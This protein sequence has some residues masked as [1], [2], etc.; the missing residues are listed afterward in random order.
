MPPPDRSALEKAWRWGVANSPA[1]TSRWGR[2]LPLD[3]QGNLRRQAILDLRSVAK[4]TPITPSTVTP[5]TPAAPA[6]PVLPPA[7]MP[8]PVDWAQRG[9]D[10]ARMFG[11]DIEKLFGMVSDDEPAWAQPP[12]APGR[13]KLWS[14]YVE[15]LTTGLGAVEDITAPARGMAFG[16]WVPGLT[17]PGVKRRATE[18]R[19][20]GVGPWAAAGAAYQQAEEAGEIPWWQ[21][22]PVSMLTSPEEAIPGIG[23][24]PALLKGGV[25]LGRAGIRAAAK[26][27]LQDLPREVVSEAPGLAAKDREIL[28]FPFGREAMQR[29]KG[30]A[31]VAISA[32]ELGSQ[33]RWA[34]ALPGSPQVEGVAELGRR[35]GVG[36]SIQVQLRSHPFERSIRAAGNRAGE[37]SG[38]H[39]RALLDRLFDYKQRGVDLDNPLNAEQKR[40]HKMWLDDATRLISREAVAPVPIAAPVRTGVFMRARS[41]IEEAKKIVT[42]GLGEPALVP[43]PAVPEELTAEQILRNMGDPE[44][45]ARE[46]ATQRGMRRVQRERAVLTP[47]EFAELTRLRDGLRAQR[48]LAESVGL[49]EAT[50]MFRGQRTYEADAA[51]RKRIAELESKAA[52][53]TPEEFAELDRGRAAYLEGIAKPPSASKLVKNLEGWSKQ[54]DRPESIKNFENLQPLINAFKGI[55]QAGMK[56]ADYI[57]ARKEAFG[58]IRQFLDELVPVGVVGETVTPTPLGPLSGQALREGRKQIMDYVEHFDE[59]RQK[60]VNTLSSLLDDLPARGSAEEAAANNWYFV[61]DPSDPSRLSIR[62]NRPIRVTKEGYEGLQAES[63]TS[64]FMNS[65]FPHSGTPSRPGTVISP[66]LKELKPYLVRNRN[67]D[68]LRESIVEMQ[69]VGRKK[70]KPIF[71]AAIQ[72]FFGITR[73]HHLFFREVREQGSKEMESLGAVRPDRG[74]T[75]DGSFMIN[76][77]AVGSFE[78][79]GPMRL[80]FRALHAKNG[81]RWL[82]LLK[83]QHGPDW[84]RQYDNLRELAGWEEEL[85]QIANTDMALLQTEDYFYRGWKASDSARA[86]LE[87]ALQGRGIGNKQPY[88]M[89]RV[90]L[91]FEEMEQLGFEP[92]YWNPYDQIITRANQG[93]EGRLQTQLLAILKNPKY[94]L[95]KSFITG[96]QRDELIAEGYRPVE[97]LGSALKPFKIGATPKKFEAREAAAGIPVGGYQVWAN[98]YAFPVKVASAIE[99]LFG[100]QQ[101]SA[102]RKDIIKKIGM[103]VEVSFKLD[104]IVYLPKRVKLFATLF[105]QADF[106]QRG[107]FGAAGAFLGHVIKGMEMLGKEGMRKQGIETILKSHMHLRHM[108]R[109]WGSMLKANVSPEYRATLRAKLRSGESLYAERGKSTLPQGADPSLKEYTWINFIENGLSITDSAILGAEDTIAG[110]REAVSEE[111]WY[112]GGAKNAMRALKELEFMMR[113]G[114]FDGVYVASIMHDV[115]YNIL[116]MVRL[117][118][119]DLTPHEVMAIA[120]RMANKAWSTIPKEQSLIRGS[121][122]EIAKRL[123]FSINENEGLVRSISGMFKGPDKLYWQTRYVGGFLFLGVVA[124]L[125]H[126]ATTSAAGRPELLPLDRYN[127]L[128]LR[129]WDWWKFGYNQALLAPDLPMTT[130]GGERAILDLVMQQDAF[131][132]MAD[133]KDAPI[134]LA[135][136]VSNR[137]SV[138]VR[139]G[140]NQFTGKDFY[141]RDIG[142][143]GWLQ[144]RLQNAYDMFAPIGAG[145]FAVAGLQKAFENK[146]LGL[147]VP[148]ELP[149]GGD[150]IVPGST[151]KD[152]TPMMESKLGSGLGPLFLQGLGFN[153]RAKSNADLREVMVKNTFGSVPQEERDIQ[154]EIWRR[155]GGPKKWPTKWTDISKHPDLT[156]RA[157]RDPVN[158]EHVGEIQRRQDTG[159]RNETYDQF[160][161]MMHAEGE[162]A[163]ERL[164]KE[165][166]LYAD[167]VNGAGMLISQDPKRVAWSPTKWKQAH[168]KINVQFAANREMIEQIYTRD[169]RTAAKLA[170]LKGTEPDPSD[171]LIWALWHW[172]R[173][174]EESSDTLGNVDYDKFE[175]LWDEETRG[176]DE[177]QGLRDRL[178]SYISGGEHHPFV[179]SY[180]NGLKAIEGSGYWQGSF[181]DQERALAA[182]HGISAEQVKERW[183]EYLKA[184]P[185]HRRAM[186]DKGR[187]VD[188]QILKVMT[189]ARNNHR[190]NIRI[191]NPH[192]D[193]LLVFWFGNRPKRYENRTYYRKLYQRTD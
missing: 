31:D 155:E 156:R 189:S 33:V 86:N 39:I 71:D 64:E 48:E 55:K 18:L 2:Q 114:L 15:P 166:T 101:W 116:P 180:Y 153:V 12:R 60:V 93:L 104:D 115:Q 100:G 72:R 158:R 183:N 191:Q 152:I 91:S 58:H 1:L 49:E 69:A 99:D 89:K 124:N 157:K 186:M 6:A 132:R 22:I 5:A 94:G 74:V 142:R 140:L 138:P 66:W 109:H 141:G 62:R 51:A 82:G 177:E 182:I 162:A 117:M 23:I 88:Q 83:A 123:F 28:A 38:L 53:S 37:E 25:R 10:I 29:L 173:V 129:D 45:A 42:P 9:K 7:Q 20:A 131:F 175:R 21:D 181:P 151:V 133:W 44:A 118:H 145:Q 164:V 59:A 34:R 137:L 35:I 3:D 163:K 192:V 111:A 105:Q 96:G 171:G 135:D 178:D 144:A 159:V 185:E 43:T 13:G 184:S 106:A 17:K 107:G 30:P 61:P 187:A 57:A 190:L 136:F 154:L 56:K 32:E 63:A 147:S 77:P 50:P 97:G 127:P 85:T 73:A 26:P 179:Q 8:K 119:P 139:A 172:N 41:A 121:T 98:G 128:N 70:G 174:R 102:F 165:A 87:H 193:R 176:W 46:A 161:Q 110:I 24:G 47:E 130:S 122:R 14:K 143:S 168:R 170:R 188:R 4:G 120:A 19:E 103:G 126:L 65:K 150:V 11:V 52:M 76:P 16:G 90:G 79:P 134:P 84:G 149:F 108:P 169:P 36:E 78:E 167:E 146:E 112:R 125:I 40:M 148:E 95:A 67:E 160:G 75:P 92:L 68:S 27:A 54:L 81:G 80:L 113:R